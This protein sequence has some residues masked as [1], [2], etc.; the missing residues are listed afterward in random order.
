MHF[1]GRPQQKVILH[2]LE[3]WKVER[4]DW[5]QELKRELKRITE[6]YPFGVDVELVFQPT[7]VLLRPRVKLQDGKERHVCGEWSNNKITIYENDSLDKCIHTLHHEFFEML[8]MTELVDPYVILSN[9][10]QDVFRTITYLNQEKK[11]ETFAKVEDREWKKK[12]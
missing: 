1:C 6:K 8:L 12:C 2:G 7:D 3:R 11:I 10:L 9:A 5:N 4:V